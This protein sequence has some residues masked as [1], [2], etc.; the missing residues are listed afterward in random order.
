MK[1][2]LLS[3]RNFFV[4]IAA[5]AVALGA[6]FHFSAP[7]AEIPPYKTSEIAVRDITVSIDATG[8][9]EPEDLVDVGARVSGEILEFGK[10]IDGNLVDYGSRVK[11]GEL[12][13]L[14]DDQIPQSDLLVAQA[15]LSAANSN[16]EQAKASLAQATASFNRAERDWLRIKNLEVGEAISQASHDS[17]LSEYEQ[18]AAQID[19]CKASIKTAQAEIEQAQANVKT[20]ERNLS[21]CKIKAPVDGVVIDRKVNIGQTV[22]SNM[23]VSSLF[24]IAKDL[25]KME[26]WASVNEADIGYV[27]PGQNV[28]FTVDAMPSETFYGKVGKIRLNATMSQ[29]VV[30]YIVEVV[31]DN[32]DE[33][34]LPYLTANLKFEVES[35]KG[36]L[37]VPNSALRW[38]PFGASEN[39]GKGRGAI[40]ILNGSQIFKMEVKT[41]ISDGAFTAVYSDKLKGGEIVVTGINSNEE[42]AASAASNPFMPKPPRMRKNGGK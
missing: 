41:G 13:A 14:I 7:K 34:L 23:S 8:T 11:E 21:Y 36:V 4:L 16:L 19:V 15:K 29:N 1:K 33:K 38:S 35:A 24:S 9:V 17:Y 26:V 42:A 27:K 3:K 40:W 2:S 31:V 32:S 25:K 10:D 37:S 28:S 12:L 20:A 30:T 5:L 18:S 22:V 6:Y 39:L